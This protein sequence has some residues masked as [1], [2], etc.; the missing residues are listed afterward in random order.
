MRAAASVT[1]KETTKP[2]SPPS[3]LERR[4]AQV[5]AALFFLLCIAAGVALF[6]DKVKL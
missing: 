1:K 6:L 2:E 5:L 4:P 3:F